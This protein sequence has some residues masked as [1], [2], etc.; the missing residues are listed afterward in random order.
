[1]YTAQRRPGKYEGN[2]S[3]LMARVVDNIVSNGCAD[4][5]LGDV[6]W[7]GH[8]AMVIGR[9][10]TFL[11]YTDSNGFVNVTWDNHQ[12]ISK[13]WADLEQEYEDYEEE[14][15]CETC[16]AD[17]LADEADEKYDLLRGN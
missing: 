8:Y 3:Q 10:Y 11:V 6:S 9:R 7:F 12:T 4:E 16:K 14:I 2:R 1:M 15:L 13:K 5:E 17:K